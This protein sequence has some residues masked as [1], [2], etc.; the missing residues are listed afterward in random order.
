MPSRRKRPELTQLAD[1]LIIRHLQVSVP[2]GARHELQRG[3]T[4]EPLLGQRIRCIAI[5]GAGASAPLLGRGEALATEL[6]QQFS[7][8]E[9]ARKAEL[10]RLQRVYGL[11]PSDFETRLAA[12][13]RT[14]DITQHVRQRIA[15]QYRYR[16]PT[17]LGYELLAH[18]LKHRFLDA[19]ISFNFDELLDQSLDDELGPNEY[20]RLVSDRDCVSVLRDPDAADYLPLYIKLHGT[21]TEPESLRFTRDA[22]YRLPQELMEVVEDLLKSQYCAVVN[23]GSAMTGFDLHR[24]LRIPE[25]L[26]I[27]DLSYAPLKQSVRSEITSERRR[28]RE[29]SFFERE[30]RVD[31]VFALL[32]DGVPTRAN[33]ASCD[34]WLKQLASEIDHR[35]GRYADAKRVASLVRFR[36]VDRHEAIAEVLGPET[37]LSRWTEDPDK[38]RRDYVDYL[39]HR[40]IVELALSGAK[41]RGLA[42]VS[43]L[44]LDRCGMYYDLYRRESREAGELPL[45]WRALRSSAGLDE[46]DWLPDVA[47]AQISLCGR[48]ARE[49]HKDGRWT[50][51]H[52][53]PKMLAAHVVNQ[54]GRSPSQ[55]KRLAKTFKQLQEASEVEIHATDDKV[56]SKAFDDPI[57]LPTITSLSV[58]ST[59]LFDGLKKTDAVYISCETGE[60]LIEDEAMF[61]VLSRQEYV[62]VITAF[63]FKFDKLDEKYKGHLRL[64]SI[65]PWRHNRHMTIVCRGNEPRRAVYFARRLRS[66]LITP[67]YL[68]NPEDAARVMRTFDLMRHE[69]E[70]ARSVRD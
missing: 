33:R 27:Y 1:R 3:R 70:D 19:I 8:E 24:L 40:T 44:A 64:K 65:D 57:V 68:K 9:E 61:D 49:V 54:I 30:A 10:F 16:H 42:Q 39:R 59:G 43:W 12:L 23:V 38:Y 20:R 67:V 7:S 45:S 46:N 11:D 32:D 5:V 69:I 25:R 41:A 17:I 62:E 52:F 26:E 50:L 14:P 63:D 21:A 4:S 22:Y 36:S 18:L 29:D 6:E 15:R 58:F 56:C 2:D 34:G 55:T 31:P 48:E 37:T 28:P 60:W 35:C 51:R 13:S 66:P 53:D 47:E